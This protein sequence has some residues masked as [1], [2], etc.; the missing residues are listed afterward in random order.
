M[1]SLFIRVAGWLGFFLASLLLSGCGESAPEIL[2]LEGRTMG[3]TWHVTVVNAPEHDRDFYQA[4]IQAQVDAVVAKMSTYEAESELSRFNRAPAGEWFAL[5]ADT[6]KVIEEGQRLSAMSAGSFDITVGPV[7]NLWGFGPDKRPDKVPSEDELA[8]AFARVGHQH[9]NLDHEQQRAQKAVDAYV[10]LSAIAKGY[11]VDRIADW[12]E[13]QG[14]I[15]YLVEVGGEL[16]AKG[17]KPDQK[18]WRIAIESPL[19]IE[20]DVQ[21]VIKVTDVAIATSGDYR[22]YFEEQGVR[23]SHTIDPSTGKPIRHKL[24]SVTVLQPQCMTADGLATTLMVMGEEKGY[25]FAL[26]HRIPAFFII[27]SEQGFIERYTPEFE[28]YLEN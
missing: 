26:A 5:S 15:S 16:R 25:Q 13:Q 3:T 9:I 14:V 28:P 18:P 22:N 21:Q 24:A 12:L 8:A 27:K 10:D 20:R 23:Y 7:V 2:A 4:G 11:G 19:D 6:L 17:H 1:T